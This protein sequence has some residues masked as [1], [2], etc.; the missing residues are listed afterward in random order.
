MQIEKWTESRSGQESAMERLFNRLD[1]IYPGLWRNKFGTPEAI[2]NWRLAWAEAFFEENI[3]YDEV[4]AGIR[5]CRRGSAFPPSLPEFLEYCRSVKIDYD[6]A[7]CEAVDQMNTRRSPK[8]KKSEGGYYQEFDQDVWSNPAIYWAARAMGNDLNRNY[9][10]VKASWA[11]ELDKV[12]ASEVLPVPQNTNIIP[13]VIPDSKELSEEEQKNV[14]NMFKDILSMLD[15]NQQKT[16][17]PEEI[18]DNKK[19]EKIRNEKA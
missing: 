10:E 19:L 9:Y 15:D 6:K 14:S 7:F 11:Y 17:S 8:L 5:A 12:L 4:A 16:Q 3:S 13:S 2:E 1:G 18:L